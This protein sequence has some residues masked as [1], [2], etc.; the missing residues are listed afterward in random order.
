MIKNDIAILL[1]SRSANAEAVAKPLTVNARSSRSVASFLINRSKKIATKTNLPV[2]NFTENQQRGASFGERFTNAF[3]VIFALGFDKVIAIGNDCLAVETSDI[4]TA[5]KALQTTPSVLGATKAGG[6]YLI[7][8]QKNV[9]QKEAFQ[10]IHWQTENTFPQLAHFFDN[11]LVTSYFLPEKSDIN[12]PSDWGKILPT[13]ADFI[14]KTLIQCLQIGR[15]FLS[16]YV[17]FPI[18]H[19][20]LAT[21][22]ALRAP[23]KVA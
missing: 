12:Q 13:I 14:Y 20:Y 23:P 7:G 18:N 3:E 2:F 4:L 8:L 5:A 1:F 9:F 17:F 21:S 10:N 6:A 16:T 15:S 22:L 19:R 11:Q